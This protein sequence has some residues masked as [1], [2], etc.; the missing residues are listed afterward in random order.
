MSLSFYLKKSRS[1]K[2]IKSRQAQKGDE[3]GNINKYD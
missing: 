2:Q 3:D 1:S